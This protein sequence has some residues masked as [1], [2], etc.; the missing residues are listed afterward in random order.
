M[1]PQSK[2]S[3]EAH[4][5]EGRENVFPVVTLNLRACLPSKQYQLQRPSVGNVRRN[6]KQILPG[7][8]GADDRAERVLLSE[9]C[10]REAK[11]K[12]TLKEAAAQHSHELTERRT[13]RTLQC[14][15]RNVSRTISDNGSATQL[16]Y[17]FVT[18]H[19]PAATSEPSAFTRSDHVPFALL[20]S[21]VAVS[22]TS[23]VASLGGK[24]YFAFILF[25]SNESALNEAL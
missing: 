3:I 23:A 15:R 6:I 11:R 10:D 1:R 17:F 24:S 4:P 9:K 12:N 19:V 16:L 13:A 14:P 18:D 2:R 25:P 22:N 7:P 20:P 5:A 21:K 8:P